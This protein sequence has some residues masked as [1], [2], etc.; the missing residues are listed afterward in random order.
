MY[1]CMYVQVY[2]I[3]QLFYNIVNSIH[4]HVQYNISSL[5]IRYLV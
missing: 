2:H 4:K 5:V 1:V 3:K